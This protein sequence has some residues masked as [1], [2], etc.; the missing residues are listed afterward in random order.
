[1]A[2]ELHVFLA[3]NTIPNVARWQAAIDS[4][5]FDVKLS[6]GVDVGTTSGLW[7]AAFRGQDSGFEFDVSPASGVV[8]AYPNVAARV[9]GLDIVGNFRWGGDINEMAC[10]FA[11]AAALTSVS[12]GVWFDPQEGECRDAAGAVKE[13]RAGIAAADS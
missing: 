11:A 8:A 2:L 3:S 10:A 4:Y 12:G 5:G 1:M 13:A 9:S 6:R 7:P